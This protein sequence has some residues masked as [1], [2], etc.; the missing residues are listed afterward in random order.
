MTALVPEATDTALASTTSKAGDEVPDRFHLA[1]LAFQ[2][3]RQLQNGAR[4]RVQAAGHK[5]TRLAQLEVMAGLISWDLIAE[6][7]K[8]TPAAI[9]A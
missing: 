3:A 8:A 2:R 6:P 9:E 4:P 5:P 7:G 1:A